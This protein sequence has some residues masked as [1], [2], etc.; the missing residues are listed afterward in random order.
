VPKNIATGIDEAMSPR[1][2]F[3]LCI[4]HE[5]KNALGFS[6]K[7]LDRTPWCEPTMFAP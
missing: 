7:I 1:S 5:T 4:E 6:D 2:K 3:K